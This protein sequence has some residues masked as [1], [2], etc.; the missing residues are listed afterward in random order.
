[1]CRASTCYVAALSLLVLFGAVVFGQTRP[2]PQASLDHVMEQLSAVR[3]FTEVAI[4]PDGKRVAWV[5][6]LQDKNKAPAPVSAISV[7]DLGSPSATARR[8]TGGK[9]ATARW[10]LARC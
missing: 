1:M 5:E 8:I 4:S 2:E 9:G 6:S 3:R 7:L 10:N